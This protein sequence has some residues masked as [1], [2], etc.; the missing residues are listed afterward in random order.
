MI[1]VSTPDRDFSRSVA[2]G[3]RQ[4][5]EHRDLLLHL[6]ARNLKVKYKRSVLGFLWTLLNPLLTI[7]I[8]LTI[9]GFVLRLDIPKYWAFLLSGYFV[10]NFV[11]QC[12]ASAGTLFHQHS[13]LLRSAPLPSEVLILGEV[14]S[15]FIEFAVELALAAVVLCMF[16]HQGVP[17]SFVT[18]PVLF[19]VML[20]VTLGLVMPIATLAAYYDDVQHTL[21]L[22][23]LLL[24][25]VSPVFY[26][27]RM[28]PQQL[29][30]FYQ[31]NPIAGLLQMFQTVLYEG[32]FPLLANVVGFGA[33]S[34]VVFLLGWLLF[35]RYRRLFPE[36]L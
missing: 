14:G 9:F 31:M 33:I 12:L 6:V 16:H 30:P 28:V 32:A 8:M 4:S 36:I 17:T 19:L 24:F 29:L 23:L 21:P 26:P 3:V 10:W 18:L 1:T 15:R 2:D 7:V 25:Y 34:L 13:A 5:W 11:F 35:S 27:P 22:L 20:L